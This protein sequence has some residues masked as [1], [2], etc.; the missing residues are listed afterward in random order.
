[1]AIPTSEFHAN[2]GQV[3]AILASINTSRAARWHG[4]GLDSWSALEWAGAMCGEAGE[5]ANV[6]KKLKRLETE[7]PSMT[8]ARGSD[9]K[10]ELIKLLGKECADTLLYLVLL[11]ARY[12][13]DLWR[14]VVEVFNAKSEQYGFPERL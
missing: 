2:G 7:M 8:A 3:F 6:A 1:M 13:I 10:D 4:G 12:D 9:S 14:A 5:A 11:C